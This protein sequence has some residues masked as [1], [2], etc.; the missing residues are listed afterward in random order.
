[1]VEL[2]VITI[3]KRN[4]GLC[5]NCVIRFGELKV[6]SIGFYEGLLIRGNSVPLCNGVHNKYW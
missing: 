4:M 1:M 5:F 2:I 6:I 3:R